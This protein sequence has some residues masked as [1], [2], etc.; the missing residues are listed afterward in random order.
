MGTGRDLRERWE[1][2]LQMGKGRAI[3]DDE[4]TTA[5]LGI[6]RD[7][8]RAEGSPLPGRIDWGAVHHEWLRRGFP[9]YS[10]EQ[11]RMWCKVVRGWVKDI[12]LLQ[13]LLP[14]EVAWDPTT[15]CFSPDPKLGIIPRLKQHGQWKHYRRWCKHTTPWLPLALLNAHTC[16]AEAPLW[17]EEEWEEEDD[18]EEDEE[19]EEDWEEGEGEEEDGEDEDEVVEVEGNGEAEEE[20]VEEVEGRGREGW[21]DGDRL[22]RVAGR[23][24]HGS[25]RNV[26]RRTDRGAVEGERWS[27][28]EW[29]GDEWW[30]TSRGGAGQHAGQGGDV[31]SRGGVR[32]RGER[33]GAEARRGE[34][35]RV[36]IG[37]VGIGRAGV[38]EEDGGLGC[39][40]DAP[41]ANGAPRG[42]IACCNVTLA[43]SARADVAGADVTRADGTGGASADERDE[44]PSRLA[45]RI[46]GMV[47]SRREQGSTERRG[48]EGEGRGVGD[49][50]DGGGGNVHAWRVGGAREGR[51]GVGERREGE[52][53]EEGR[54]GR[55]VKRSRPV[56]VQ[57]RE[58]KRQ[59]RVMESVAHA[60][61]VFRGK[62]KKGQEHVYRGV[63]FGVV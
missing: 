56:W 63:W 23:Y 48:V 4:Q 33:E 46:A 16:P 27:G 52:R 44:Y 54:A 35:G 18:E 3:W 12:Q 19:G 30:G 31:R 47:A 57:V 49:G 9:R 39:T 37:R 61:I 41:R 28:G 40:V 25:G 17:G 50:G 26:R 42:E 6:L 59:R 8:L 38:G 2:A 43:D 60:L 58:R 1:Q 7:V 34:L 13:S 22:R 55:G 62:A 24:R 21:R 11:L 53:G 14:P 51:N 36:G 32:S 20:E 15:Q 10:G 45:A 29:D 5:L